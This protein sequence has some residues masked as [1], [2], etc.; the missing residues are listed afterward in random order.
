M[1]D[2]VPSQVLCDLAAASE[3]TS[4]LSGRLTLLVM[5]LLCALVV[6]PAFAQEDDPFDP[7]PSKPERPE[8]AK[9]RQ[10]LRDV[11][12]KLIL[13]K[14]G[15]TIVGIDFG[16]S[17]G[18]KSRM[19]QRADLEKALPLPGL[20]ILQ[21]ER[22]GVEDDWLPIIAKQRELAVLDLAESEVT[23]KGLAVLCK[24]DLVSVGLAKCERLDDEAMET[25]ADWERLEELCL[26]DVPITD[27]GVHTI[28]G[29]QKLVSLDLSNYSNDGNKVTN[30][31]VDTLLG[32][33]KLRNLDL[34]GTAIREDGAERFLKAMP[35]C[36]LTWL[37]TQ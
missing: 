3:G 23:S 37:Q 8:I 24:L 7:S 6:V 2:H 12:H 16:R 22:A 19:V 10:T 26:Q 34:Y 21:F 35:K 25:V 13:S 11:R 28:R 4:R 5:T 27:A 14:D 1:S 17:L 30:K 32:F 15:T 18:G 9:V 29:L 33:S 36:K 20:K 31:S